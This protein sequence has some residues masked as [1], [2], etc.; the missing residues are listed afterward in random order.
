MLFLGFRMADSDMPLSSLLAK[1]NYIKQAM[2][3]IE[4]DITE[5]SLCLLVMV[6]VFQFMVP[7]RLM[8]YP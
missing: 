2:A 4:K 3:N 1:A 6:S 5:K 7:E 8:I